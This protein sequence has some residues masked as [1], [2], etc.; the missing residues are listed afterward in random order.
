LSPPRPVTI[1]RCRVRAQRVRSSLS[2]TLS[3]SSDIACV[4]SVISVSVAAP[5]RPQRLTQHACCYFFLLLTPSH[6][7]DVAFVRFRFCRRPAP[8][9]PLSDVAIMRS[10]CRR[11]ASSASP[12]QHACCH[13]V[14]LLAPSPSSHVAFVRFRFCCPVPSSDADCLFSF[15]SQ[16]CPVPPR[17]T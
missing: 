12:A 16:P 3:P 14:H 4:S 6:S 8:S 7:S 11:P 2:P 17:L 5:P 10:A 15:L 13:F 9:S 1:V